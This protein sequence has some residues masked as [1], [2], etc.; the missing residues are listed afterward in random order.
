[1]FEMNIRHELSS[2]VAAPSGIAA[3]RPAVEPRGEERDRGFDLER[4]GEKRPSERKRQ[5]PARFA[6]KRAGPHPRGRVRVW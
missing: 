3:S 1:M 2:T 6:K 5:G 4:R